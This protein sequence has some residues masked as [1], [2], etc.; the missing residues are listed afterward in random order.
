MSR[1]R[2]WV[3]PALTLV[4]LAMGIV[5]VTVAIMLALIDR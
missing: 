2:R 5:A 4:L 3:L 1:R